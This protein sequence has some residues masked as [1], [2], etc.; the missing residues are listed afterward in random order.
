MAK[1]PPPSPPAP[2]CSLRTCCP[3][4]A[5]AGAGAG[6]PVSIPGPRPGG[7]PNNWAVAGPA[8][9]RLHPEVP[10]NELGASIVLQSFITKI[11]NEGCGSCSEV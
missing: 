4:G 11:V 6:V 2:G 1:R 8:L 5:S 3:A 9:R 10:T 7:A